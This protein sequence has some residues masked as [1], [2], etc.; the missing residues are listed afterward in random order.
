MEEKRMKHGYRAKVEEQ[1]MLKESIEWRLGGHRICI[2][3]LLR[4]FYWLRHLYHQLHIWSY[5]DFAI[6]EIMEGVMERAGNRDTLHTE[7]TERSWDSHPTLMVGQIPRE[8][9]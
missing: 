5:G 9:S 3:A 1:Y 2:C 4:R 8:H 6:G 7:M